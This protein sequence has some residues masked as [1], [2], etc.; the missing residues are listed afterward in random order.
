[1]T[2]LDV[3]GPLVTAEQIEAGAIA[4]LE[5]WMPS[6]LRELERRTD[7]DPNDLPNIRSYST[8]NEFQKWPEEQLP[9]C[10]VISPG[11]RDQPKME[12]D[13]TYRA[14]WVLGVAIVVSTRDQA[15]TNQVAKLY[16]TAARAAILQHQSL[17][18]LGAEG[19]LWEAERYDNVQQE[20]TRTIAAANILFRVTM[21]GVV[22]A[23]AGLLTPPVDPTEEPDFP[24]VEEASATVQAKE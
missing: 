21:R 7:R 12:G 2:G 10:I 22:N 15:S 11:T 9:A 14:D 23:R 6:Y 4:H 8:V 5:M 19:V 16:G 24:E 1:M 20:Q 18:D 13:G 3:Y 17:G